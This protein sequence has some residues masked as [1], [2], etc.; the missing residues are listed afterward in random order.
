[1]TDDPVD[2]A[3]RLG[4]A[5]HASYMRH[6]V[7]NLHDTDQVIL[8]L[9]FFSGFYLIARLSSICKARYRSSGCSYIPAGASR[10]PFCKDTRGARSVED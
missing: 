8:V 6:G 5:S 9:C 4:V 1:L 3:T 10:T 7:V 2:V